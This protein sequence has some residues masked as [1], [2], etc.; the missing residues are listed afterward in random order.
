MSQLADRV[1]FSE[2]IRVGG[3]DVPDEYLPDT[4]N[5]GARKQYNLIDQRVRK[6]FLPNNNQSPSVIIG[7]ATPSSQ[8]EVN[9]PVQQ[10]GA[11]L[12]GPSTWLSYQLKLASSDSNALPFPESAWTVFQDIRVEANGAQIELWNMHS[13]VLQRLKEGSMSLDYGQAQYSFAGDVRDRISYLRSQPVSSDAVLSIYGRRTIAQEGVAV[14]SDIAPNGPGRNFVLPLNHLGIFSMRA[15]YPLGLAN[16]NV[17]L[18]LEQ[19]IGNVLTSST[20]TAIAAGTGVVVSNMAL[21]AVLPVPNPALYNAYLAMQADAE[22]PFILPI[23]TVFTQ[24][25]R[26]VSLSSDGSETNITFQVNR[27]HTKDMYFWARTI[28]QNNNSVMFKT[29]APYLSPYQ[30]QLTVAGREIPP[31][32]LLT[33]VD[34]YR[35]TLESYNNEDSLSHPNQ[36]TRDR[37]RS[38]L[39]TSSDGTSTVGDLGAFQIGFNLE[40]Y[41]GEQGSRTGV[42]LQENNAVQ[43]ISRFGV[44][45]ATDYDFFCTARYLRVLSLQGGVLQSVI[46]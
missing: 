40:Q 3:M 44:P 23:D 16:I 12:D 2:Q 25:R 6:R 1:P 14:Y 19:N 9:I 18:V 39:Y 21:N 27:Q 29:A 42:N 10:A 30:T 37:Y 32:R 22:V 35:S 7:T 13:Q 41:L 4:N 20:G 17:I 11:L 8:T 36:L 15:Y 31:Q 28:T 45:V 26:V 5:D 46:N 33:D 43:L 34:H 38:T 24:S